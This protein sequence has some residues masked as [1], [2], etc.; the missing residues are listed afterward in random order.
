MLKIKRTDILIEAYPQ[1][2][3]LINKINYNSEKNIF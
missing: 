2:G 1:T 3:N